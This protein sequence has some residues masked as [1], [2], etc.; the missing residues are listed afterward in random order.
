MRGISMV[1]VRRAGLI[2]LFRFFLV[3]RAVF[4][5]E[6]DFDWMLGIY[7]LRLSQFTLWSEGA[8]RFPDA[9]VCRL[10]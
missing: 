1:G 9:A 4:F 10:R 8:R 3:T 2:D 7:L 5:L 6:Q